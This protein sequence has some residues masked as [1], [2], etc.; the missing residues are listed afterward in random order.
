MSAKTS[1]ARTE[2]FFTAL[3]ETGNQTISAERARVSRSWVTLHRSTDPAFKARMEA[4]IAEAR[5]RLSRAGAVA[6]SGKWANINGEKLV[7]RGSRGRRV[8]VSRARLKQWTA[9]EEARFLS[10]LSA[11]CNVKLACREVGLSVASAHGHR[12]RWPEFSARWEEALE[13]GYWALQAAMLERATISLNPDHYDYLED[14]TPAL[15]IEPM[16]PDQCLSLL[17][18]N[19]DSAFRHWAQKRGLHGWGRNR[20]AQMS[21][22]EIDASILKRLSVLRK[23]IDAGEA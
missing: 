7:V 6:S 11:T 8:Q 13:E 5:E 12:Q 23:R 22:E 14:W 18:M 17:R 10:V 15:P 19:K 2:A 21:R 9:A 3:A 20:N 4:C 1:K 16:T